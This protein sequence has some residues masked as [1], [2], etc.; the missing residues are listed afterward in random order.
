M[1]FTFS[2]R[3]VLAQLAAIPIT[4]S[5]A[6]AARAQGAPLKRLIC[7]MQNNGTKRCNFWPA[8][9]SGPEYPLPQVGPSM[10][11]ILNSLFT[12]DGKTDNGLRAKTTVIKGLTATGSDGTN[13]NGHDIGFIKTFTG[14]PLT[15]FGGAPWGSQPSL[16]QIIC[17]DWGNT[18]SLT[19]AVY[20]SS[21]EP[22]PKTGFDH[23]KSFSYAG[24]HTL[25]YPHIDPFTAF[26]YAFPPN[27]SGSTAADA[28]ARQRIALR[29]SVLDSVAGDLK[30]LQGRLGPDDAHKLDYHLTAITEVEQ[31][32]QRLMSGGGACSSAPTGVAPWYAPGIS[33]SN[34]PPFEVNTEQYNDLMIQF[35]ASLVAAAIK[36]N[37]FRVGSLQIGYGGGKAAFGMQANGMPWLNPANTG[38]P[39]AG[40]IGINHH[41]GIAHHDTVDDMSNG[42]TAKYVTWINEYYAR[43]VQ[44]IALALLNTPEGGGSMLDNT[45]IIWGNELGRGDHNMM[46]MPMIH[47]G[48]VGNG[49]KAGGRVIDY[50]V[51][52][53][54][55]A[56]INMHGY[57]ALTAL[58]HNI[59]E[60]QWSPS[61]LAP[62]P[63]SG[64]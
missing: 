9:G 38:D 62:N 44:K 31:Q 51:V 10:P 49:Q 33:E 7:V 57:H 39:T 11:S 8:Q 63:Y 29:Q 56:P 52:H 5:F 47:I 53:G 59:T 61:G 3:T 34:P 54:G 50:N 13:A 23:R 1:P 41:D 16:D 22:H 2:R 17:K 43:T 35:M 27:V 20:S 19:T 26:N 42:Q 48:L 18:P 28:A 25:N 46:N 21:I 15:S 6:R 37:V 64:Y 32:L 40:M 45:L 12:S 60:S 14:A 24:P 36:C 58:G 4:A 55:Q 30:D